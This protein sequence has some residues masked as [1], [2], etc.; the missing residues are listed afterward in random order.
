MVLPRRVVRRFRLTRVFYHYTWIPWSRIAGSVC[1]G[2]R[3][4]ALLGFYGPLSLLFLILFWVAVIIVGFGFV[5]WALGSAVSDVDGSPGLGTDLYMS[6]TTFFTLGLGDVRP[7]VPVTKVVTVVEAGMGFGFL[8]LVVG[9]FPA[10]SQSFSR[11]ESSI[12]KLDSRAGSPPVGVLMLQRHNHE[13]GTEDLRQEL[14]DWEQWCA[15]LLESHLSYPVL[16]YYRS[17]HDK[18]SWLAALTAVLDMSALV[19]NGPDRAC[20]RQAEP[21]FAM[22]RHAVVDIAAVFNLPPVTPSEDRLP[23]RDY[24]KLRSMLADA[25]GLQGGEAF[26]EALGSVRETYEPY[27]NSLARYF[28]LAL[29]SWIPDRDR[30]ADWQTSPWERGP[31]VRGE[32]VPEKPGPGS[33]G[34][35]PRRT[36]KRGKR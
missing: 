4:E 27:V 20:C 22:A 26:R 3:L 29:P 17:Q 14:L 10:L 6:G 25:G 16:A 19:L 33:T 15:E 36:R 18:Q 34:R 31:L 32:Y 8:A 30:P 5:H 13:G 12:S 9:Y 11:R 1:S 24:Q 21:T 28:C 7:V 35:E 2:R 23:E